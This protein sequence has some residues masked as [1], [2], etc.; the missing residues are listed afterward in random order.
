[1]WSWLCGDVPVA[2]VR[3]CLKVT[4]KCQHYTRSGHWCWSL[5]S[6]KPFSH[7]LCRKWLPSITLPCPATEREDSELDLIVRQR[8]VMLGPPPP[9]PPPHSR[10]HP[11]R[12]ADLAASVTTRVPTI[13]CAGTQ[14]SSRC[15]QTDIVT[16]ASYH[17]NSC[18][19]NY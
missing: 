7:F 18:E 3:D 5:W 6:I 16:V 8:M 4:T 15:C 9:P 13:S 10:S 14:C 12:P 19:Q 11:A 17:C 2:S 1:M